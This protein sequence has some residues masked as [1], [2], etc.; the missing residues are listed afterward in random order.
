MGFLRIAAFNQPCGARPPR[1]RSLLTL[2]SILR[3]H[4]YSSLAKDGQ[5]EGPNKFFEADNMHHCCVYNN[6]R[7]CSIYVL[8]PLLIG[9]IIL[10]VAFFFLLLLVRGCSKGVL[11]YWIP[12]TLF[13]YCYPTFV[14]TLLLPLSVFSFYVFHLSTSSEHHV[15]VT[16]RHLHLATSRVASIWPINC[17]S[18]V[19][20]N[21]DM[22]SIERLTHDCAQ[23]IP[24]L[25]SIE[26]IREDLSGRAGVQPVIGLG[27]LQGN[28]SSGGIP[29]KDFSEALA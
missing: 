14:S 26:R 15:I 4:Q 27:H 23:I 13:S 29:M 7:D 19:G 12:C 20:S 21:G 1:R 24:H 17:T 10:P 25:S 18:P 9:L 6:S 3:R 28:A 22:L 5:V 11:Q 8:S 16:R 2:S